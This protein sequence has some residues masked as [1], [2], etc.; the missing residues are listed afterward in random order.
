MLVE[1]Y[2]WTLS[3]AFLP[4]PVTMK[5]LS[6]PLEAEQPTPEA[7]AEQVDYILYLLEFILLLCLFANIPKH[8]TRK[9]R[10][11]LFPGQG[12]FGCIFWYRLW[13]ASRLGDVQGRFRACFEDTGFKT[14]RTTSCIQEDTL[15]V[16]DKD[17]LK[18]ILKNTD[19]FGKGP[20][21]G[22]GWFHP[23]WT[24]FLE[25][26]MLVS[27]GDEW[28]SYRKAAKGCLSVPSLKRL[29]KLDLFVQEFLDGIPGA[30]ENKDYQDDIINF[31]KDL[32]LGFLMGY[33]RNVSRVEWAAIREDADYCSSIIY[34]RFRKTALES[35]LFWRTCKEAICF[36]R[37]ARRI[38]EAI[39][40]GIKCAV[41]ARDEATSPD[42]QRKYQDR[43]GVIE[44]LLKSFGDDKIKV[45]WE[46]LELIGAGTDTTASLMI[47]ILYNLSRRLELWDR[48]QQEIGR[49]NGRKPKYEDLEALSLLNA[50]IKESKFRI[51]FLICMMN[52]P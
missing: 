50:I 3:S 29:D 51:D 45:R 14:F 44:H 37:A 47:H 8:K 6:Y 5:L 2:H 25:G 23:S 33:E 35:L 38:H 21:K 34:R 4:I 52:R 27:D 28:K 24:P 7:R 36:P 1:Q 13:Q 9:H 10:A 32:V 41:V 22:K 43:F 20:R 11:P 39:D 17:N 19:K 18:V 48:L 46:V 40:A 15:H 42:L 12:I 30:G 31:S 26:G 16:I 49:L